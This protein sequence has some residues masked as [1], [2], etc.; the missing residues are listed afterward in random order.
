MTDAMTPA[1]I[2][3][4]RADALAGT[5]GDWQ[6]EEKPGQLS[7]HGSKS[8][9]GIWAQSLWDDAYEAD[10]DDID[11]ADDAAW[12]CGI[13]GQIT[14]EARANARRIARVPRMETTIIAL[15]ETNAAQ[16][17]EIERMQ[18]ALEFTLQWLECDAF[19]R[20]KAVIRAALEGTPK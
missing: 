6:C 3:A 11:A 2:A 9:I 5:Q 16:A 13:W 4:M 10:P 20:A 17:A 1:D 15:T 7:E 12:I 14:D 8:S 19:T 18:K